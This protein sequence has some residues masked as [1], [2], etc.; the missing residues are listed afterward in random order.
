M[1]NEMIDEYGASV[2]SVMAARKEYETVCAAEG[3]DSDAARQAHNFLA[4]QVQHR[5]AMR[6]RHD[7]APPRG[8]GA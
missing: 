7:A 2:G 1:S 4:Q 6:V 5:E 8:R 3:S